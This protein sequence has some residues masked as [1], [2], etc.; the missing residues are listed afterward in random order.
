MTLE[1][2]LDAVDVTVDVRGSRHVAVSGLAVD[3]RRVAA[4]DVFFACEGQRQDGHRFIGEAIARG[5]AAVVVERD[6]YRRAGDVPF[7]VTPAVRRCLAAMAARFYGEPSRRLVAL[8]VTGT[9]GKTTTTYL[10]EAI[11]RASGAS[12]GVIG[13]INQRY[14]G[15]A[16]PAPLTT[17]D[18]LD[19]QRILAAMLAAGV[20]AVAVEVSSHA[21]AL[22]RVHGCHWDAAV[23]TNLTHDH[24]DFHRDLEDYY[25]A[26]ARLFQE[27]LR[28]SEKAARV[29]VVGVD[30]VFGRRLA[31][32]IDGRV[33]TFGSTP[34]AD[35]HPL[36]VRQTL[37]GMEGTVSVLG[38]PLRVSSALIGVH[39][40]QNIMA[41]AGTARGLGLP[42]DVVEAGI[43]DCGTPP[44]RLERVSSCAGPAVFV[45]YAHTP[46]ALEGAIAALRALCAGRLIT[47]FG[48]GGDR[49]RSKRPLMGEVAARLSDVVI[50]TSDNPRTEDPEG[51]LSDIEPGIRRGGLAPVGASAARAQASGYIREPDRRAAIAQALEIAGSA[52]VVLIAGKGHEDY[53]IIGTERRHFDDREEVRTL[54]RGWSANEA[55]A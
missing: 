19:L 53:Q 31:G 17:P 45:D 30:N 21:L 20:E 42:L 32:E 29:A 41:A 38:V 52:D 8:A 26:K 25:A 4:G 40:L 28:R 6:D 23:F 46:D 16:R 27:H 44:G 51:I 1:H 48:C 55:T 24:L 54:L 35:V 13:T 43:R 3:S 10:L 50:V 14:A 5:A 49:D 33:V 11:W 2:L 34:A 7:V 9:N 47:V 18:A 12:A 39:H 22:D 36:E 37:R 15:V